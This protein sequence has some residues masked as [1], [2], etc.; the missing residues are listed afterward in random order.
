MVNAIGITSTAIDFSAQAKGLYF[1]K[2]Q[3][4]TGVEVRKFILEE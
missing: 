4:R 1:I 2:L 3:T